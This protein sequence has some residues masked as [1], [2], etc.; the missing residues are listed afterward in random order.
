MCWYAIYSI[1]DSN[2]E[3]WLLKELC[4]L[5]DSEISQVVYVSKHLSAS[6][7]ITNNF[8]YSGACL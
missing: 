1:E 8:N 3:E 4:E 7:P 5:G 2:W 6:Q